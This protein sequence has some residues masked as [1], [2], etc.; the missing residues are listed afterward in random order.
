MMVRA[1]DKAKTEANKTI[2]FEQA[3][4]EIESGVVK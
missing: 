2:P 1:Y 3:V 4:K